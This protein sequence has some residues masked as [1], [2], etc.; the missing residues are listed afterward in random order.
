MNDS[1]KRALRAFA[2][3][4]LLACAVTWPLATDLDNQIIGWS[5][6]DNYEMT[7]NIWWMAQALRTGQDMY[8]QSLLGYPHGF[9]SLPL[10]ANQLQYFPAWAFA[11]LVSPGLAYNLTVLLYLALNG[12]AMWF[13][14]QD[15]LARL[16]WEARIVQTAALLAGA[17]FCAAPP[18][19]SRLIEGHG[20]LMAQWPAP[21]YLWALLRLIDCSQGANA[22]LPRWRRYALWSALFFFLTPSGHMLQVFTMLMPILVVTGIGLAA[23]GRW[24]A[25]WRVLIVSA[26]SGAGLLL[27]LLP[28]IRITLQTSAYVEAGGAVRYSADL[29]SLVTPSF[30]NPLWAGLEYPRRVLGV[31][32]PEGYAYVG[33]IGGGLA[34]LSLRQPQARGWWGLFVL[35]WVLSLGPVLKVFDAPLLIDL[36]EVLTYLPLPWAA[37]Q[38]WPG[39][40]LARAPGRFNVA[41]AL[42]LAMLM[43]YGAGELLR[44]RQGRQGLLA[45]LLLGYL[46]DV[47]A[48]WPMPTRPAQP[49]PTLAQAWEQVRQDPTIRAVFNVPWENLLAAKDALYDQTFHQRPLIA[50]QYTRATPVNS[51][52]LALLQETLHPGLLRAVGADLVSFHRRRAI[53]QDAAYADALRAKLVAQL[54]APFYDDGELLLFRVPLG[55]AAPLQVARTQAE[56]ARL[57]ADVRSATPAWFEWTLDVSSLSDSMTARLFVDGQPFQR[58]TLRPQDGTLRLPVPLVRGADFVRA[59]IRLEQ[60]C[61]PRYQTDLF[62]CRRDLRSVKQGLDYLG[63]LLLRPIEF[64]GLRL[65]ASS[66]QTDPEAGQIDVALWW[67]FSAALDDQMVRFLHVLDE[68]SQ[69]IQ[70]QDIRLGAQDAGGQVLEWATLR[71]DDLPQG[72]RPASLRV[73]WYRFPTMVRLPLAEPARS[74]EDDAPQLARLRWR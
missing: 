39:F 3:Y 35:A 60:S 1:L 74:G 72:Q 36:D 43:A 22:Y 40:A 34:L 67:Q 20:G 23:R 41:L 15:R 45:L 42:A 26:L 66:V 37:V 24:L 71:L 16:G 55:Q 59:E 57:I 48:A 33:L 44:R 8:Y 70:G 65:W 73:G 9:S 63:P 2:L 12:W 68:R 56:A 27:T 46:I 31:N 21:L 25:L 49:A 19:Q 11:L 69:F 17:A 10:A 13:L 29:L 32:L 28:V 62:I 14:A 52:K 18:L 51:A 61:P 47:Q 38:D 50:G 64:E 7:R 53:E 58:L 5:V 6:G 30:L 54:G 4:L